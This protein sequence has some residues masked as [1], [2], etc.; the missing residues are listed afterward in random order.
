MRSQNLPL[1]AAMTQKKTFTFAKDLN[2]ESFQALGGWLRRWKERN[3][4]TFKTKS[5]E[6]K[7]V[8][9]K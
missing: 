8:T 5:G 3:Y 6:S 4:T 7:S 2:V 1:S 9:P